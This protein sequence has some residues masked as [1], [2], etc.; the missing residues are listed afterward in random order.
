MD[1]VRVLSPALSGAAHAVAAGVLTCVPL[2]PA[3]QLPAP[4]TFHSLPETGSG[5]VVLLGG[6]G[7]P[8]VEPGRTR[9]IPALTP[10][11]PVLPLD[12]APV[13]MPVPDT[14]LDLGSV[15]LAGI[16]DGADEGVGLCLFDCGAGP[17]LDTGAVRALP[18]PVRAPVRVRVG[19]DVREPVKVRDVAPVYPP[20]A[21][22]AR[23][24][25]PVV[26]Q[27]VIT[28]E[29]TVSEIAIVSGHVLLNDAAVAAVSRWRY[30]P[31][32]LDGEPVGVILMVTVT[33]SLR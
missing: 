3:D 26:L 23:V 31:T 30:R 2:F 9:V 17:G 21:L 8:R 10:A 19:G 13:G 29:G 25:G 16:G 1:R 33:F 11:R 22:A 28:T 5:P 27:C 6:G 32:L 4:P 12:S 18:E 20:L 14:S 7:L 24:Q 15:G